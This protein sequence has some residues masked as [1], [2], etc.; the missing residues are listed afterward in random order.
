M[1]S[2]RA[3]TSGVHGG[4]CH[5]LSLLDRAGRAE[6]QRKIRLPAATATSTAIVEQ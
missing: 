4:V 2:G 6:R 3:L 1:M 5:W